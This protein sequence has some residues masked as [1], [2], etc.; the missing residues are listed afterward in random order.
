MQVLFRSGEGWAWNGRG[1]RIVSRKLSGTHTA[2]TSE[3]RSSRAAD[4][5][6]LKASIFEF[7]ATLV[8]FS[9]NS[10]DLLALMKVLKSKLALEHLSPQTSIRY[11]AIAKTPQTWLNSE[12]VFRCKPAQ[13]LHI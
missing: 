2:D 8:A 12:V 7:E 9:R 10:F 1:E 6:I 13:E 3:A 11:Q 5:D 4:F